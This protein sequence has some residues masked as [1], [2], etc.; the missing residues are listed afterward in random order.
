MLSS[1]FGGVVIVAEKRAS[2]AVDRYAVLYK[3]A[4]G[5]GHFLGLGIG[6]QASEID[7]I[8]AMN[9]ELCTIFNYPANQI[10]LAVQKVG[11]DEDCRGT[12]MSVRYFLKELKVFP[13]LAAC[14]AEAP[15]Y[16]EGTTGQV[17]LALGI[18]QM[19]KVI[20]VF[21]KGC[22]WYRTTRGMAF[23]YD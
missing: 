12:A 16:L 17:G 11:C 20:H 8:M 3:F 10:G 18:S 9:P 4:H 5:H 23:G 14:D 7:M 21:P 22:P 13:D 2:K 15:A 19:L 1:C 6:R